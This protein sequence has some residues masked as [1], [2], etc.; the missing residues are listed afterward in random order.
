VHRPEL[1]FGKA[2]LHGAQNEWPPNPPQPGKGVF[3]CGYPELCRSVDLSGDPV[4]G[5]YAANTV[6]TEISSSII[7]S[8][9]D[10]DGWIDHLGL[11]FP[12]VGFNMSGV[13]GSPLIAL[14]ETPILTWALAGIIYKA[15][16]TARDMILARRCNFICADGSIRRF[17]I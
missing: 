5:V 8:E 9:F 17:A 2:V 4:F 10:R 3:F 15:P 14:F 13:S 7:T 6:V 12:E 16:K 1:G 11:G